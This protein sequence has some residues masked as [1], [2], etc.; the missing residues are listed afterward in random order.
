M[1]PL[2]RSSRHPKI[3][4][5]FGEALV[6]YLLSKR[7]FECAQVDHTGIDLIAKH[8][9]RRERMGISVKS[10][11]R[12]EGAEDMY[13]KLPVDDFKKVDDACDAFGCVPYFAIVVDAANTIRVFIVP[14]AHYAE[15]Y[16]GA[17]WRM[18]P[19]YLEQ[20]AA[21]KKV[22]SFEFRGREGRWW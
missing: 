21:D 10:R 18:S 7:G 2:N 22:M 15:R 3:A 5:D 12:S 20:Y 4:G 19:K 9:K 16:A 1:Q 8:P 6:L 11:T 17:G 14:K 13:V